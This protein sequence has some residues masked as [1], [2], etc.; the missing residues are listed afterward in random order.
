MIIYFRT[1]GLQQK[2]P[3][4]IAKRMNDLATNCKTTSKK[5]LP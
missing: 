2:K 4:N 1:N 5:K 3:D